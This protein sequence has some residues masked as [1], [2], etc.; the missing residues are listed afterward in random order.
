M[1]IELGVVEQ[2][3]KAV[4]EVLAGSSVVEA[5]ER[6][7]VSRQTLLSCTAGCRST[8][9][10]ASAALPTERVPRVSPRIRGA[11]CVRLANG[12]EFTLASSID[13]HSRFC[14]SAVLV[15]RAITRSVCEALLATLPG[16]V[17][18][19]HR[20]SSHALRRPRPSTICSESMPEYAK[21]AYRRV[22]PANWR[23][24]CSRVQNEQPDAS[25]ARIRKSS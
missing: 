20:H 17:C 7:D 2:R 24:K 4:L 16:S 10:A 8:R 22:S 12:R 6:Y 14:V 25:S 1:L 19:D 18:D 23:P 5:A 3:H 15:K 11:G 9:A 21:R 13:D